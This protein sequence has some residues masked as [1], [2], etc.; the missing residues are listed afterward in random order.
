MPRLPA[1]VNDMICSVSELRKNLAGIRKSLDEIRKRV[2]EIHSEQHR[3]HSTLTHL[4]AKEA[5]EA[6]VLAAIQSALGSVDLPPGKLEAVNTI[7]QANLAKLRGVIA[8]A[9]PS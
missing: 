7:I 1:W 3:M 6:T 2:D 9:P 8:S 5:H 4:V